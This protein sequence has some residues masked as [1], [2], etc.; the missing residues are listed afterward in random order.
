MVGEIR[1][2][3]QNV[4]NLDDPEEDNALFRLANSLHI[5]THPSTIQRA[6]L[7]KSG[8]P[9]SA[10][11]IEES[12]RLL[13]GNPYLYDVRIRPVAYRD[14]V[15]DIEVTTRDTWTLS[16]NLRLSRE[17]G[18][19][20]TSVGLKESNLLGTGITVGVSRTSD[21]DRDGTEFVV[22]RS[23]AFDGRTIVDYRKADFDDGQRRSFTLDRPF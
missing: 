5:R 1:I 2:D 11:L 18:N 21:I 20:A 7:F 9:L 17:G 15:V 16:P 6:L 10:R 19:N 22:S 14:G 23:N 13:R 12:E 3:T 4:F 8:E